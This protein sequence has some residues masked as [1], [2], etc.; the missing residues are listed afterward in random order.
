MVIR[1]ETEWVE[2]INSKAS[3]L[4]NPDNLDNMEN[5]IGEVSSSENRLKKDIYGKGVASKEI[6]KIIEK[7]I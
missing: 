5:M 3:F 7:I 1:T 4:V 6:R 2:L